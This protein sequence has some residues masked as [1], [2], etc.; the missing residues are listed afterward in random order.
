MTSHR[1]LGFASFF[2]S[3]VF[4]IASFILLVYSKSLKWLQL[5]FQNPLPIGLRN[6]LNI[7]ETNKWSDLYPG[8]ISDLII[9]FCNTIG[10]RKKSSLQNTGDGFLLHQVYLRLSGCWNLQMSTSSV[11]SIQLFINICDFLLV[12][13][14]PLFLSV[15]MLRT[16]LK[17]PPMILLSLAM[18]QRGELLQ[19]KNRRCLHWGHTYYKESIWGH[20]FRHVLF[21]IYHPYL[22]LIYT[23]YMGGIYE[24]I[25]MYLSSYLSH[26]RK[27]KILPMPVSRHIVTQR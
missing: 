27:I 12:F 20:W 7:R 17:S 16:R 6:G 25:Y 18:T 24:S 8:W 15:S 5:S 10:T 11:S 14:V 22:V 3:F 23:R 21:H 19:Y 13:M 9:F 2:V 26:G 1:R 4:G